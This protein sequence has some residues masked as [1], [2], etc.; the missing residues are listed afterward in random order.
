VVAELKELVFDA[1]H[2]ADT[3]RLGAALAV[4]LPTRTTVALIG[5][6]GAGKTRLVQ[7]FATACGVP[8]DV[9]TSPT[10]VLANEYQGRI[11][12]Y[13]LDVY[14]LRDEDEFAELG[15][16]EYFESE[17]VTFVEWADRVAD[18][19]PAERIEIR[20]EPTGETGRR[21]TIGTTSSRLKFVIRAL[22]DALSVSQ[23]A[24]WKVKSEIS[25]N[26]PT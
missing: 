7:A 2:E 14:R 21:F 13:H 23:G 16:V 22:Y 18:L 5:T 6:L 9:A 10:F 19:M 15:P 17:G 12:I 20:C 25:Q 11:P 26:K 24:S 3:E 1:A 4:A 8:R